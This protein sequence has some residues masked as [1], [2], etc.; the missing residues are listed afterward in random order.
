MSIC[1]FIGKYGILIW[2]SRIRRMKQIGT[3]Y[4]TVEM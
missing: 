2:K 1:D 3:N 4:G